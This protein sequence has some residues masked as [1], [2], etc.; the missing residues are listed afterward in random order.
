VLHYGARL[1]A[2]A[3]NSR[4]LPPENML[5]CLA[6]LFLQASCWLLAA[7]LALGWP[8]AISRSKAVFIVARVD[9]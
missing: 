8:P 3:A 4:Q 5:T 7:G 6:D 1:Q 2:A 9:S